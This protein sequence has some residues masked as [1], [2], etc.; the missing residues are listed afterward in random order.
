V[1]KLGEDLY[2]SEKNDTAIVSI[3]EDT[4]GSIKIDTLENIIKNKKNYEYSW[5]KDRH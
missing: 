4:N 1:T 3:A 2:L 5:L